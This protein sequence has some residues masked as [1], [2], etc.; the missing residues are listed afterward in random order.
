MSLTLKLILIRDSVQNYHQKLNADKLLMEKLLT[1][2]TTWDTC[3]PHS[4]IVIAIYSTDHFQ[5][6]QR[7]FLIMAVF[8]LILWIETV[9]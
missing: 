5:M 8:Y 3:S 9:I 4:Y 6:L 2:F 7:L 1:L